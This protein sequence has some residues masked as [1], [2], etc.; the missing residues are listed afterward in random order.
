[1]SLHDCTSLSL[2]HIFSNDVYKCSSAALENASE[3]LPIKYVFSSWS[4]VIV[5]MLEA[6]IPLDG[7][8]TE[9]PVSLSRDPAL[10]T[11]F[12]YQLCAKWTQLHFIIK[13]REVFE[14]QID[15]KFCSYCRGKKTRC[16]FTFRVSVYARGQYIAIGWYLWPSKLAQTLIIPLYIWVASLQKLNKDIEFLMLF[17]K[18][19]CLLLSVI[20]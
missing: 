12:P 15:T 10:E 18:I 2:I 13:S 20:F 5:T 3:F 17:A 8:H 4:T 9:V 7:S 16:S 1:M 19:T 6:V 11:T 14:K